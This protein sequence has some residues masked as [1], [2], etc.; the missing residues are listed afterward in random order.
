MCFCPQRAT[1]FVKL[2]TPM[3]M[4]HTTNHTPIRIV[5]DMVLKRAEY[6]LGMQIFVTWPSLGLEATVSTG[7]F[8]SRPSIEM[9]PRTLQSPNPRPYLDVA[10]YG[11]S[12]HASKRKR[13]FRV[14]VF[15]KAFL[16]VFSEGFREVSNNIFVSQSLATKS[17]MYNSRHK[18]IIHLL[19]KSIH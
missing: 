16:K 17:A 3:I 4:F 15:S 6:L 12:R 8:E 1:V 5:L 19:M 14:K 13:I 18:T 2:K 10:F 9:L 7:T 11:L